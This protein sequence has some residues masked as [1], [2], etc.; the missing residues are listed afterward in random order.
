MHGQVDEVVCDI[1]SGWTRK[2]DTVEVRLAAGKWARV[3]SPSPCEKYKL[4]EKG[5]NV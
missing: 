2:S 4:V 5:D 1:E 3:Y